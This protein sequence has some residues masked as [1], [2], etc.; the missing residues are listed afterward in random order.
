MDGTFME[1]APLRVVGTRSASGAFFGARGTVAIRAGIA[2]YSLAGR[3]GPAG[4]LFRR[5]PIDPSK[6]KPP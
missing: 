3:L 6:E 5:H 1:R 2:E 4:I